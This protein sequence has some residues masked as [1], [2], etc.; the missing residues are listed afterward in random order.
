MGRVAGWLLAAG[1]AW[2]ATM[3]PAPAEPLAVPGAEAAAFA[4]AVG[5][6]LADDEAAALPALSALAREGNR[7]AQILLGLIDK[8]PELQGPWLAAR[9]REERI[10]LMRA[11]G[12]LSGR[13][14]MRVAAGAGVDLAGLWVELWD[15]A[16]RPDL[17]LRLAR[18]GEARA[19]RE[20]GIVLAKRE[21]TGFAALA[22]DPAFP[23]E[24]GVFAWAEWAAA[25]D[26]GAGADRVARALAA[27]DP[28]DPHRGLWGPPPAAGALEAWLLGAPAALPVAALCR[29][30]CPGSVASCAR[31]AY[32]ALGNPLSLDTLGSPSETLI[33]AADFAASP[34]GRAAVIRRIELIGPARVRAH[35]L[36]QAAATDSCLATRL[37]EGWARY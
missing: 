26:A 15:T 24:L 29:A 3:A 10:A 31:A 6:W 17:V 32:G 33:A 9:P 14:W 19:A 16:A 30:E 36:A 25:P 27:L 21:R 18:A 5:R 20:A 7:A 8:A 28:G 23:P 35:I 11:P 12:G 34:R 37:E 1:L 4:G 2:S 13:S 22:E